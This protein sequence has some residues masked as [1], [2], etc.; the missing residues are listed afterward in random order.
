MPVLFVYLM[1]C[2][3]ISVGIFVLEHR[4]KLSLLS[5][6][7]ILW[8]YMLANGYFS[9][10]FLPTNFMWKENNLMYKNIFD[11]LFEEHLLDEEVLMLLNARESNTKR[12][13]RT[14]YEEEFAIEID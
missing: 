8:T 1:L 10:I 11:E 6:E 9:F 14:Y 5:L 4:T 7:I 12:K 3:P 13:S 2:I